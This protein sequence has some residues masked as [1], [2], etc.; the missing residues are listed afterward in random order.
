MR[1]LLL[2]FSLLFWVGVT[3]RN[4]FFD[5]GILK[6]TKVNPPVISV[7]NISIGGVGKTP[8]VEML[9]ERLGNNRR[10]S[11]VSR[12]YGRKSV[13]TIVVSDG[14]GNYASVEDA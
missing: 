3:L 7:G 4:W 5:I 11:F 6:T 8:I 2:P 13:G 14:C 9:I 10:L 1:K 12:G